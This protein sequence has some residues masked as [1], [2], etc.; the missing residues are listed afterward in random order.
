MN[1]MDSP[2]PVGTPMMTGR[3]FWRGSS[4]VEV[5]GASVGEEEGEG[6]EGDQY[7]TIIVY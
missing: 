2:I 1:R 6:A 7:I 3:C 4:V 5:G